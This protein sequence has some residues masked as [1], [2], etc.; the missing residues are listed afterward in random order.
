MKVLSLFT[1]AGGLDLGFQR[2]GFKIALAIESDSTAVRTLRR[3]TEWPV[4]HDKL[5]TAALIELEKK[6]ETSLSQVDVV[7]GGPPCQPFSKINYWL[8]NSRRGLKDPRSSTVADYFRL[9]T[10]IQ[11]RVFLLE[12]VP[13][14]EY[15][16]TEGALNLMRRLVTRLE[17]DVGAEYRLSVAVLNAVE[18]GVPQRRERLFVVGVRDGPSFTFPHRTHTNPDI[19]GRE[20]LSLEGLDPY[21]T[22]WD[23]IGDL[24]EDHFD[25]DL[26]IRGKWA[27]LVPSIP[28]GE[29]YLYH[30]N[31]RTG[32]EIFGWRRRYWH[33]L[34][35][36]AKS[37]P[38]WT[39]TAQP[40]GGI[41]PF[42]WKNRRLSP[43][44]LCRLQTFPDQYVPYGTIEDIQRQIGNAVPVALAER[45]GHAIAE[46]VF[47]IEDVLGISELVPDR[48]L[49]IP[50][51]EPVKPVP[52]QYRDL[53]GEVQPHPGEGQGP[54]AWEEAETEQE[55][56][57][58]LFEVDDQEYKDLDS[59]TSSG[60]EAVAG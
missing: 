16:G 22:A 60:T 41:G 5:E 44:E 7:T 26:R 58:E 18:Y 51:P 9:V 23:A 19:E 10:L 27:N 21:R 46:Q 24:G 40:S 36:L 11:P 4:S 52:S 42:H 54:D 20:Q 59:G 43:R 30:T 8:G 57:L 35:K 25:T 55:G 13:A 37:E 12:N 47:G 2:A 14:F 31:R 39:I 49:P 28:E 45:L 53:I 34:L 38:S 3:N 56:N 50:K 1:G 6:I 33:F 29:N 48:K 32:K 17:M 15:G